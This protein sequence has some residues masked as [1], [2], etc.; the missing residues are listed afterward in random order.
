MTEYQCD[1]NWMYPNGKRV[2]RSY[3]MISGTRFTW[4]TDTPRPDLTPNQIEWCRAHIPAFLPKVTN[5]A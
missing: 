4:T 5:A 3:V 2:S 1:G